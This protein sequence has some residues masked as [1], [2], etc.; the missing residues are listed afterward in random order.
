MGVFGMLLDVLQHDVNDLPVFHLGQMLEQQNGST[1][2][3]MLHSQVG[4][5]AIMKIV[6]RSR[7]WSRNSRI[8]MWRTID[9]RMRRGSS[10]VVDSPEPP[11]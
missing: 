5:T 8:Q 4:K 6:R 3:Q 11:V 7:S 1:Y 9:Q 2:T 10:R